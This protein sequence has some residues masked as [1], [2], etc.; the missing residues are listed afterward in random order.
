MEPWN[1]ENFGCEQRMWGS[2]IACLCVCAGRETRDMDA[3]ARYALS[4]RPVYDE[5]R[6]T[7]SAQAFE[8][9]WTAGEDRTQYL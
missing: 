5:D 4:L 6:R 1:G 3:F 2:E 9:T 7:L 8:L